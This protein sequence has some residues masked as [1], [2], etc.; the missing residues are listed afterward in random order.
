MKRYCLALLLGTVVFASCEKNSVSKIPHITLV[1]FAPRDSM[2]ANIDTAFIVFKFTDGDANIGN[3]TT[4]VIHVR[5]SRDSS[6]T[7]V[8]YVFPDI[9]GSIEDPKK[10]LSGECVFFPDPPTP[11]SDTL[12]QKYGDTLFYEFYI[13]DRENNAS[14]HITTH[15]IIVRN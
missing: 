4:S 14:N 10:G 7:F 1:G 13:T 3:D 8:K 9:D 5:D 2:K 6:N 12:H 15:A 11:R